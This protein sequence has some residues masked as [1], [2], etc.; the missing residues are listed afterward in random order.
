MAGVGLGRAL[1]MRTRREASALPTTSADALD[2]KLH[3]PRRANARDAALLFV[4]LVALG[5]AAFVLLPPHA[6]AATLAAAGNK[7]PL[8]LA[9]AKAFRGGVGGVAGGFVQV[10]TFMWLRTAMNY[11]YANGGN[12]QDALASLWRDGGIRRLYQGWNF[13]LVQAPL[14]R[15]GDTFANAGVLALFASYGAENVAFASV[16]ASG[17]GSLWKVVL[18]PVDAYKTT[19]QVRGP[20]AASVLWSRVEANGIGELYSGVFANLAANWVGSY[21][22]FFTYNLVQ[23]S[24]LFQSGG[25]DDAALLVALSPAAAALVRDALSGVCASAVSGHGTVGDRRTGDSGL[26]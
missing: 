13:A 9:L 12:L 3:A 24:N 18:M 14:S 11:Q 26:R 4:A 23:Q 22:W 16:I 10:L 17:A 7:S 25:G 2:D 8:D 15:F 1:A 19:Y 20:E 21:P 6:T 5:G